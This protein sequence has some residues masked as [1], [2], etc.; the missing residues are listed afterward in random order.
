MNWFQG[1]GNLSLYFFAAVVGV[2]LI[3]MLARAQP[4]QRSSRGPI[5]GRVD[6]LFLEY[7]GNVA[8]DELPG[9]LVERRA[10]VRTRRLV[11][12]ITWEMEKRRIPSTEKER[13]LEDLRIAIRSEERLS[14]D[15]TAWR[16]NEQRFLESQRWGLAERFHALLEDAPAE[17]VARIKAGFHSHPDPVE[18]GTDGD[19]Q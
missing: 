11:E 3:G 6:R 14:A 8:L 7:V 18:T 15:G 19:R 4:D 16:E 17:M 12:E 1:A 10:D 5:R 13:F 9:A 2:L